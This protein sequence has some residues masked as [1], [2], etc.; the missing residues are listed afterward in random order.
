MRRTIGF[1]PIAATLMALLCWSS[2]ASATDLDPTAKGTVTA[3]CERYSVAIEAEGLSSADKNLEYTAP[4]TVQLS[5]T[6]TPTSK[7]ATGTVRLDRPTYPQLGAGAESSSWGVPLDGNCTVTGTATLTPPG[8]KTITL[9]SNGSFV[10]HRPPTI[11]ITKFT[12]GHDGDDANGVPTAAAG[13]FGIGT[14]GVAEVAVGGAITWTYRVTNTGTEPLNN[15]AVS[16]NRIG[17]VTCPKTTLNVGESMDCVVMSTAKDLTQ[18]LGIVYGCGSGSADN[19]K[20]RPAYVN[21]GVVTGF[22]QVSGQKVTDYN[23]SSYCNPP[24]SNQACGLTLSK[25]CDIVQPP[26]ADWAGCKGKLQQFSMIWPSSEPAIKISGVA[27]DAPG[28][29]VNP[30]QRVTFTGPFASN[31][32]IVS[33]SGGRTGQSTFHVSCSDKDMD[34]LTSTNLAQA[35]LPGKS[36]DCGKFEGDGKQG[37]SSYINSWLLDGLADADGKVLTCSPATVAQTN[38]CSFE[39]QAAPSCGT[40]GSFKPTTLTF[41]YTGGGCSTQ[42]NTQAPGKTSCSGSINPML[43]VNVVFPGGTANSVPVGGTFTIPRS[44]ANTLISLSNAGGTEND[45]VHTSCSQPLVVGDVYYSL[46]LVAEDNIGA[47]K[48][49]T[50]AYK[51]TNTSGVAATNIVVTD[52]K[53]GTIPGSPIASLAAGASKT[54]T[55]NANITQTTTN[56]A[57]AV[58]ASCAPGAM[59]TATVT[60]LPTPPCSIVQAF[61]KIDDD[62]Y[63]ITLT[64]SGNTMAT[65]DT[66]VLN[67]PGAATYG[68]I[69]EIK[70]DGSIYKSDKSSLSVGPGVTINAGDWT[71]DKVAKRQLDPGESRKLEISFKQKWSKNNCSNGTCFSGTATF[72]QGCAVEIGQ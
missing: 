46:T 68:S 35:Q 49:V 20:K 70:L 59:S 16:D 33:I 3:N 29:V 48:D 10:C 60:M 31:D 17:A 58:A 51:V 15:V 57:T 22:G 41:K 23:A 50:Y 26:T 56:I 5:C 71:E 54:L 27:N 43:P 24:P 47:G 1:R 14:F 61:E 25:T 13:T 63:T 38:A 69:K 12:N 66:F 28:G 34:G 40:G 64:N 53:L 39:P 37:N 62:K 67:W 65:L 30:G 72:A 44:G 6:G 42:N 2:P 21:T 36:Q 9:T 52:N 19:S 18:E 4:Y 55:A 45:S 32:Q 7:S 11:K 8:N